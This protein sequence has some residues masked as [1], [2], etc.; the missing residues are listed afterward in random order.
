MEVASS[1]VAWAGVGGP[2]DSPESSMVGAAIFKGRARG[3]GRLGADRGHS[4]CRGLGKRRWPSG[5]TGASHGGRGM[6]GA[7]GALLLT[8][9]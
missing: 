5:L 4:Q 3:L 2:A 7:M 8:R 1:I 6:G 9:I